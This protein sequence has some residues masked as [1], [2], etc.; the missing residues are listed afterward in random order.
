MGFNSQIVNRIGRGLVAFF[1]A[2][3]LNTGEIGPLQGT[4]NFTNSDVRR[5]NHPLVV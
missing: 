1:T 5:R 3:G 4:S 2:F